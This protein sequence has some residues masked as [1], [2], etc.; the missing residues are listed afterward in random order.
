MFR[1][2]SRWIR[3]CLYLLTGQIDSA[4]E[5]LDS[6]PVVM[7][8]QGDQIIEAKKVQIDQFIKAVSE[9]TMLKEKKVVELKR[10]SIALAKL[11]DQ[12]AG[13]IAMAK[14][15]AAGRTEDDLQ[16]NSPNEWT[17]Y[18]KCKDFYN[19]FS[20]TAAAKKTYVA[21]LTSDVAG[22][23]KKVA[24]YVILLTKEK[25]NL[26]DL[27]VK[28]AENIARIIGAKGEEELNKMLAGLSQ[29]SSHDAEIARM[30]DMVARA[31]A[32][33][34]VTGTLAGT[35]TER[36][37]AAFE[38]AASEAAAN[39]EFATLVGTKKASTDMKMLP[40]AE[41]TI[42]NTDQMD[43]EKVRVQTRH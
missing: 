10:E 33:A 8:A 19:N 17:E 30:D 20:T 42:L 28:F 37:T 31:E 11:E 2:I 41:A 18:S 22:Y 9:M 14:K 32:R 4:R 39:D 26:E 25:K 27:K 40:D 13:A 43:R 36:L 24:D 5:T 12:K 38:A 6:N 1:A 3:A 23:E 35:D 15:W 34:K 21:Q 7:R 16:K 29:G